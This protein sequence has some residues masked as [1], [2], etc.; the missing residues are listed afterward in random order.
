MNRTRDTWFR[1]FAAVLVLV[2]AA[3]VVWRVRDVVVVILVALVCAYVLRPLVWACGRPR[4]RI[5]ARSFR[6]SRGIA[7][8]VVF[9]LLALILWGVWEL[10]AAS[11]TRQTSDL[12]MNWPR[13]RDNL[14]RVYTQAG[15]I[16]RDQLPPAFRPIV[17]SWAADA[18]DL[19]TT[20]ATKALGMTFHGIGFVIELFLLPI[21][22]FYFLADGP[23]IR[24]QVLFFVPRRYLHRTEHGLDRADDIRQRYIK[25]QVILCLIAFLVVTV[26]LWALGID[27]YLLLG[28]IAGL[29]R[30][31]PIIGPVVGAIPIIVVVGVTESFAY[32]LWLLLPFTLM[33]LLESK[34]LMPAILGQQLDLHPA[35]I[36]VALLIGAQMGGLLGVFLAAPVLAAA[37]ALV[38]QQR[39]SVG[40]SP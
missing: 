12:Q 31:V 15:E 29:T 23:A 28:M 11:L 32:A 6:C 34:L 30:A 37:K 19:A 27:F 33:H 2:A 8:A 18:A 39:M 17:D 25:G 36:I 3:A 10:S 13:Y 35:L 21:L 14:V 7:T 1:T 26:G 4:L 22:T 24:R 20:T 40:R 38:E 16:Y 5:G 9:V